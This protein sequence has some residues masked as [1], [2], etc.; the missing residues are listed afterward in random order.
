[1]S[2][3]NHTPKLLVVIGDSLT[4]YGQDEILGL[5]HPATYPHRIA[6]HLTASTGEAWTAVNA[7]HG[8]RTL[9]EAHRLLRK[10]AE[11][12][13]L[14]AR[15]DAVVLE[16]CGKDGVIVPFPRP[17]RLVIGRIPKPHRG[18]L[19]RWIKPRLAKVTDKHWQL[20]S[21]RL[22]QKAWDTSVREIRALN[23]EALLVTAT[24][25]GPYGP[26]TIARFP[27]DWWSPEGF[28]A[29][30]RAMHAAAG[31]PEVDFQSIVEEH[32]VPVAGPDFL[33]WPAHV[34]DIAAERTAALLEELLVERGA[35]SPA[36]ARV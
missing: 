28:V 18:N 33:H 21:D 6:A 36:L 26:Q 31:V 20:T 29:K 17:V 10:D 1:M 35:A 22:L 7:G 23:P 16:V 24:P 11:L 32:V 13:E 25:G 5:D 2:A 8:G 15:A 4:F 3:T 19:V 30:V 9:W 27:D 14:V 12:R 34:H